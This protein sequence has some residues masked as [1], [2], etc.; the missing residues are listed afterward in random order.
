MGTHISKVKSVDLDM[1]TPEQMA[2]VTK[3]GNA[4]ANAYWEAHL[5]QGHAPPD[6]KI[7]SFIRSKYESR[8]WAREGPPPEDPSILDGGAG[9]STEQALPAPPPETTPSR[10][11][12]PAAAAPV[13]ARGVVSSQPVPQRSLLSA[14]QL[15]ERPPGAASP[16]PPAGGS[17]A[18]KSAAP[19]PPA[20]K[21]VDD[22]FSL[23][24]NAPPS[25]SSP[26]TSHAPSASKDVKTDIMS[27]FSKGPAPG[28]GVL[29][30]GFGQ[31]QAGVWG[32]TP[33]QAPVQQ[34]QQAGMWGATPQQQ[35]SA[36]GDFGS[37][38][39]APA[40]PAQQQAF[41]TWGGAPA[42]AAQHVP[43]PAAN[44][45][46]APAP[47]QGMSFPSVFYEP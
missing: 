27:L 32:A 39:G 8:R 44:V 36:G 34:Q 13:S 12:A 18:P 31:P 30:G 17:G 40:A 7:E 47:S 46:G 28:A 21:P 26:S 10:Q 4:R 15:R 42:P 37:W 6:H 43:P 19:A 23:D 45:W 29:G 33:Q 14:Q 5:K 9:A 35:V 16:H 25:T 20:P 3:W 41:G 11:A 24:F 2:N 38:G 1:W 22:I